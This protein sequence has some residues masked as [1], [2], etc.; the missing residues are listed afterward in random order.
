MENLF[1][2]SIWRLIGKI[3]KVSLGLHLI[4]VNEL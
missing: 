4:L 1:V 3:L 2:G